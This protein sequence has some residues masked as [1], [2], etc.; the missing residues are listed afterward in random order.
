[1]PRRLGRLGYDVSSD[2]PGHFG[3]TTERAVRGFQEERGLRVDGICGPQTWGSLVEAGY[4]LGDRLLYLRAP[5]LRGDDVGELQ[6]SLG[7]LGFDAGRVDGIFGPDAARALQEFQR[8]SGLTADGICGPDTVS[9]L[10]R[11]AGRRAGPTSV[12]QA[13]EVQALR[14]AP[15]HLADRRVVLGVPGTLD[16]LADRV[17]A[18]LSEAGAV[19]TVLH[20]ADGSAQAREAND[21][22]AE[23][24]VG[25]RLVP[26][27]TCRVAYYATEGFESVGGRRLAELSAKDL[28]TVLDQEGE[29]AGMRLPVLRET[30]MPAIVCSLGPVEDVVVHAGALAAS[31]ARSVT[32]W[33]EHRLD[34]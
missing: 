27:A 14:D 8:N 1:M 30:K 32:E 26:E 6:E 34:D 13:R 19:V 7:A 21:L 17:Q 24:Y 3:A 11:L 28:G 25:L 23:L 16:A 22:S 20:A 18:L 9:A 33:V 10:R 15:R 31:L 12:A 4:Q 5:M 29:S 2:A